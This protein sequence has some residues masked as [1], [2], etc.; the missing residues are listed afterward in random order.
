MTSRSSTNEV[1]C[2]VLECI[3]SFLFRE[4]PRPMVLAGT[5]I[6]ELELR[7]SAFYLA[8]GKLIESERVG[9]VVEGRKRYYYSREMVEAFR[10]TR[11]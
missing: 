4:P 5:I 2:R 8:V 7:P 11:R 6:K 3:E 1:S 9:E 10:R